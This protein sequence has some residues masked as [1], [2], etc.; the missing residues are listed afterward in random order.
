MNVAAGARNPLRHHVDRIVHAQLEV[1][2]DKCRR[3]Y[4]LQTAGAE[5]IDVSM[6]VASVLCSVEKS[7]G[8]HGRH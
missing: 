1:L 6:L 8:D 4:E 7:L 3:Q 2:L 5:A